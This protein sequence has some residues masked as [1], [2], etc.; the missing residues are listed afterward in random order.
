MSGTSA[1]TA[2]RRKGVAPILLR[3][4]RPDAPF[5]PVR[6]WRPHDEQP[7]EREPSDDAPLCALAFKILTDRHAGRLAFLRVYSGRILPGRVVL[8]ANTGKR[9]RLTKILRMHANKREELEEAFPTCSPGAFSCC[10]KT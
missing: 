8:N 1:V 10:P 9:E 3:M 5:L 6:G 7:V 2:A 4:P